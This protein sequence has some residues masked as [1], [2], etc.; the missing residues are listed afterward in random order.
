VVSILV[1]ISL[2]LLIMVLWI[3]W[4]IFLKVRSAIVLVIVLEPIT[5]PF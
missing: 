5:L 3:G 2:R 4:P 1:A